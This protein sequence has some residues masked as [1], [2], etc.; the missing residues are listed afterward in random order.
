MHATSTVALTGRKLALWATALA[1]LVGLGACTHAPS[2]TA[3]RH[4]AATNTSTTLDECKAWFERLD[5]VTHT[6]GAVDAQSTRIPGYAHVRTDRLHAALAAHAIEPRSVRAWSD[7]LVALDASA[8]THELANL[9]AVALHDLNV[10]SRNAAASRTQ[11][12]HAVMKL[13]P[14]DTE[15][16]RASAKV[17][18]DYSTALR[19][20]GAYTVTRLPFFAGVTRWQAQ[21]QAQFHRFAQRMEGNVQGDA[22]A[23]LRYRSWAPRPAPVDVAAL[24]RA[25]PRDALGVLR[26]DANQAAQLLAAYA[27]DF[28]VQTQGSHDRVGALAWPA[29]AERE[30]EPGSEPTPPQVHVDQPTVYTRVTHTLWGGQPRLQLVYTV[31]FS[32]R[33]KQGWLGGS[34]DLLGGSLDGVTWRVTLGDDGRVWMHDS[35]HPCGCYHLFIPTQGVMAKA[36]PREDVEW[37]YTPM[38][39]PAHDASRVARVLISSG[40]HDVMGVSLARPNPPETRNLVPYQMIDEDTLR[41]LPWR[42]GQRRSLYDPQGL[43]PGTQRL[44]RVLFWPMGIASAGAMR[45]WGRH[46]TAFVGRRHFDD[47]DLMALRFHPPP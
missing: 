42:N 23:T 47:P 43:V 14:L 28:D 6:H 10:P 40:E 41:S 29:N 39:V 35:I 25:I 27:P 17:P 1:L 12:C 16:L 4:A 13:Q 44:E 7:A 26:P 11:Q 34:F 5:T 33:P 45:Q 19:L 37:A 32:Q 3:M 9:P 36:A 8:R 24:M 21:S 2:L 15:R 30:L 46:A 22:T 38:R 18:D 20:A 31:W